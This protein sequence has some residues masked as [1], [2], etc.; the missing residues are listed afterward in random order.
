M[1]SFSSLCEGI[2]VE[3]NVKLCKSTTEK[4][5]LIWVKFMG[6]PCPDDGPDAGEFMMMVVT[7]A[8]ACIEGPGAGLLVDLSNVEYRGG[9]ELFRWLYA[10]TVHRLERKSYGLALVC[11][12]ANRPH[13]E[14]LLEVDYD[15]EELRN[16]IFM[17]VEPALDYLWSRARNR[18]D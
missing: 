3:W 17:A 13:V 14:T 1:K 7:G 15:D 5:H 16:A 12:P 8:L 2:R 10:L 9:D 6:D 4:E 11:S 18:R